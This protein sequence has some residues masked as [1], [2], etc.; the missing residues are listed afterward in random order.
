MKRATSAKR[1]GFSLVE[2]TI[3][4]SIFSVIG[5]GLFVAVDAGNDSQRA[6]A[7]ATARAKELRTMNSMLANE[8]K[9]AADGNITVAVLP[10]SN[11]Q[12]TF[13][14]PITNAGTLSWGVFDPTLGATEAEQN[15]ENWKLRYTVETVVQGGVP[16]RRLV[17]QMLDDLDAIQSSDVLL[18]GLADG[19]EEPRGFSVTKVGDMW[20]VQVTLTGATA[21]GHGGGVHFHVRTR[22]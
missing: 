4:V 10:D 20:E 1:A 21:G 7:T 17:R 12:V 18:E 9:L 2:M 5:Y 6:V 8:L 22:N 11:D 19:L 16:N 14:H 13:M 3:A 15:R